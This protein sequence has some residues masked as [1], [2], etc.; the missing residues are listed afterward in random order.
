[1]LMK[2]WLP[3]MVLCGRS[4]NH[5]NT[6]QSVLHYTWSSAIFE[7]IPIRYTPY[8]HYMGNPTVHS[9]ANVN[10]NVRQCVFMLVA[11]QMIHSLVS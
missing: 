2:A 7:C 9:L 3:F 6:N 1:M 4:Q 11:S 5:K 10:A 8:T